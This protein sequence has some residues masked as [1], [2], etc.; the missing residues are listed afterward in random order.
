M[1]GFTMLY[2]DGIGVS[3]FQFHYSDGTTQTT[4]WDYGSSATIYF[5]N[6]GGASGGMDVNSFSGGITEVLKFCKSTCII[7]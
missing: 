3:G 7:G 6:P 4:G 5:S 1:T 2:N